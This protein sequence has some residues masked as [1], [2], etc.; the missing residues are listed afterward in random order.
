MIYNVKSTNLE[1][2][3]AIR[4]YVDRKIKGLDKYY[5]NIIAID[6][7]VGKTTNHHHKGKLFRAEANVE[8]PNRIL[9]AEHIDEDLYKAID[10]IQYELKREIKSAKEK[11]R[12]KRMRAER[13]MR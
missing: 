11:Y 8:I 6:I 9:R 4:D 12:S 10:H 7:E 3:D 1:L 5:Q 2:T 13:A